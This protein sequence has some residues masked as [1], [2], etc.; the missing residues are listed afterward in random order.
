MKKKAAKKMPMKMK[1][2]SKKE[3][4]LDK[5]MFNQLPKKAPQRIKGWDSNRWENSSAD[6][7]L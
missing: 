1:E 6:G 5:R 2:G 3:V 7:I 4:K